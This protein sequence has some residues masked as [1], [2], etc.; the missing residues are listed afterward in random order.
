M[1]VNVVHVVQTKAVS[2]FNDNGFASVFLLDIILTESLI[3]SIKFLII[4]FYSRIQ[5][6]K[7]VC[8][9]KPFVHPFCKKFVW[10]IKF[11]CLS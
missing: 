5:K 3:K 8:V 9:K 2:I 7:I 11:G 4:P 10:P 6:K 1:N